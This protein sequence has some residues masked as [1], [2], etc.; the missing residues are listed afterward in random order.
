M[1]TATIV[2]GR[3]DILRPFVETGVFDGAEV[4]LCAAFA[5]LAPGV[6]DEVLVALAVA[7]RGPRRGH[8]CIELA[9]V[10]RLVVD[11]DEEH[12]E[13][14]PW[15]DIDRW[16]QAL[17]HSDL[18]SGPD[19][20][21]DQPLR[22][23]VWDGRRLYLQRLFHDEVAVADDLARRGRF[24]AGAAATAATAPTDLL[25]EGLE[26]EATL[27]A[28]FGRDDPGE[29]DLQRRAARVALTQR[30]SVIAGGPGTGKTRTIARLLAAAYRLAA[31][32]GEVLDVVLA[33][34]TGKAAARMTDALNLAVA[35]AETESVLEPGVA[36]VLHETGATTLH[37]LLGSIPG[38][39]FRRN[40]SN[41]LPHDV[42]I[43][44]ETSM[45][46][47]PLMARLLDAIRPNARLVLVGDP[48][49]LA[50]IEA[51]SVMSDVVGP[52]S[53]SPIDADPSRHP[54]A[55]R[56]TVLTRS[57]RFAPD[58]AIAAVA[59]A[60]RRGDSDAAL[61]I[62]EGDRPGATWIRD[63]DGAG[64]DAL[65]RQLVAA[66]LEV[67]RAAAAG[68]VQAGL[69]AMG[70]IK[71]LT[72]TRYRPLGLYD[73]TRRIEAGI[74]QALPS[75]RTGSRWYIGR[76]V[77]VT[78]NDYPNGLMN[79]DVGLMVRR[80]AANT[81]V[82]PTTPDLR[83]VPASQLDR[84]ETWWAMTI[85]K[86]QGSELA[87]AIVS[88]PPDSSPILTREL[89]Y[90]AVTRAVHQITVVASEAAIRAAIAHPVAR[91]SGLGERLWPG[92]W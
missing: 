14:L 34:P 83:Y 90:T 22:P 74:A 46:S 71:V 73:W 80:D 4:Q 21:L 40:S 61:E 86:S 58:S 18:V 78:A 30:I 35:E 91:A 24:P 11:R 82:F 59:T 81:V 10:A 51:G 25:T 48:F 69:D 9:D 45:V 92:E 39:G 41:P 2:P 68:E 27:D 23:L 67:V 26:L 32:R 37:R 84:F 87:H 85:H 42:V 64:I 54:L 55:G 38:A 3:V 89:L 8:V 36:A 31:G 72:A 6:C 16:A 56:V 60:V 47:L 65:L 7:A 76:P 33:A 66:A 1:T 17:A 53:S 19:G 13:D 43:V 50:S 77:I 52:G 12:R 20:Y 15:P 63:T 79:G 57:R 49:Q 5:R 29:P 70:R 88:L 62:L 44:D 28:L 75:V